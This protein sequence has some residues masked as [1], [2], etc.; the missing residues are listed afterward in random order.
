MDD[1]N[2]KQTHSSKSIFV[3]LVMLIRDLVTNEE[4]RLKGDRAVIKP[5]KKPLSKQVAPETSVMLF[6]KQ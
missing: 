5:V 2:T 3:N 1:D 6:N 4:S